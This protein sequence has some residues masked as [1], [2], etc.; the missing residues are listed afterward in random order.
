MV[1]GRAAHAMW[2]SCEMPSGPFHRAPSPGD[3]WGQVVTT[4]GQRQVLAD[5]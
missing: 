2:C 3:A 5:A 1:S 4:G